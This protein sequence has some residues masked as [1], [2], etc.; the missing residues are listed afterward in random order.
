TISD[1]QIDIPS[2]SMLVD[3]SSYDSFASRPSAGASAAAAPASVADRSI[4]LVIGIPGAA[5]LAPVRIDDGLPPAVE[6][7]ARGA[8]A[9]PRVGLPLVQP[10]ARLLARTLEPPRERVVDVV[11][12]VL[13][14][15][16]AVL[17]PQ[18]LAPVE[19]GGPLAAPDR[20]VD[21]VEVGLGVVGEAAA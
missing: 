21:G 16:P 10:Q 18:L 3:R 19:R 9:G 20:A 7:V 13:G 4:S 6:L 8:R 12:N 2:S 14:L 17:G 5:T 11:R 1:S 15:C